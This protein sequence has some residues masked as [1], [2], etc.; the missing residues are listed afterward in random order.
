[1]LRPRVVE[2]NGSL[3]DAGHDLLPLVAALAAITA[4]TGWHLERSGLSAHE[5]RG[6]RLEGEP[7]LGFGPVG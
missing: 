3:A 2:L 5:E 7:V 1:M 6:R 4:L